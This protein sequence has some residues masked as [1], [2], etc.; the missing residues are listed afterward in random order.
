MRLPPVFSTLLGLFRKNEEEMGTLW[1]EE[2]C[3]DI[4]STGGG[5]PVRICFR[6]LSSSDRLLLCWMDEEGKPHHFYQMRQKK[7]RGKIVKEDHVE[8]SSTGHS[9]LIV[10]SPDPVATKK[11][12]NLKDCVTVGAYRADKTTDKRTRIHLVTVEDAP[13]CC[14]SPF[15][16]RGSSNEEGSFCLRAYIASVDGTPI[17]STKKVYLK[18]TNKENWILNCE[19]NWHNNN[20]GLE[21][22]FLEDLHC[23]IQ[24]LPEHARN[25][26][27]KSTPLWL[28]K[29]LQ[30]GPEACPVNA[31]HMCFHPGDGWLIENG[32]S[33]KKKYGVELYKSTD[34]KDSRTCW[35]AGGL[36]LHELSHAYHCCCVEDGY[37]NTQVKECYQAAMDDGLYDSVPVTLRKG[38]Q[39]KRKAYACTDQMEYFAEL[40]VAFLGGSNDR[41]KFNKWFPFNRKDL[42]SHDPRAY[43]MLK[44]IW[45]F[46]PEA[47]D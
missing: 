43:Q 24:A 19:E 21:K 33:P 45:K 44:T 37:E 26:L 28:N 16:L 9:F 10:Q 29:S 20:P 40:S 2:N 39:E 11:N 22:I 25:H 4:K 1:I 42:K 47:T 8:T 18:L 5:K 12:K 6:N 27:R 15:M 31:G 23:A 7:T 34:Y 3:I 17:D 38:V 30:Y 35:Q 36:L 13:S 46:D 32:M 14:H 41:I